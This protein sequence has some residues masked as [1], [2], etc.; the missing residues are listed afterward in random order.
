MDESL[1]KAKQDLF[2]KILDQTITEYGEFDSPEESAR[3]S[4]IIRDIIEVGNSFVI[5]GSFFVK[6]LGC[7]NSTSPTTRSWELLSLQSIQC[8]SCQKLSKFV[9]VAKSCQKLPKVVKSW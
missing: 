4:A 2:K 8:T 7:K 3:L 6:Q 9:K 5:S 1:L